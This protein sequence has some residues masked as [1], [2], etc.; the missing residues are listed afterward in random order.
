MIGVRIE[1]GRLVADANLPEFRP[2]PGEAL[3]RLRLAGICGTDRAVLAGYAGFSGVMGH[4]FVG[5]VLEA[6]GAPE[7]AGRRVV[8]NITIS[9]GRCRQCRQ[10]RPGH[11]ENRRVLGL[12]GADGVFAER[13]CL[14][15]ENLALLPEGVPDEAGVFAEPL[16]AALR[17]TEQ[18]AIRAEDRLLVVGAGSLGQLIAR[19]LAETGCRL[20]VIA[21]HGR[22][23]ERLSAAGIRWI[24][25]SEETPGRY[26]LVVEA[27][28]SPAG[29]A[30][31]RRSVRPEGTVVLKSSY[32]DAIPVDLAGL[33]VDEVT[34]VGSRCG[35][36]A[37]AVEQLAEK[38]IDPADLIEARYP[39]ADAHAAFARAEAPGSL[40]VLMAP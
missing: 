25:E 15:A 21:R 29:F 18:V 19:V 33:V 32:P 10:K 35:P 4:E 39:L 26:D 30:V 6:P 24:E 27:T 22:Q 16:A 36:L 3:V 9:C 14:P 23:K 2:K 7:L 8:G 37:A 40:K 1:S 13:F 5:E 12:R 17:V 11:C 31:A 38:R 28:G 34:V 20:E